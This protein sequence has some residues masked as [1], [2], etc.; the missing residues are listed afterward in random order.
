MIKRYNWVSQP[1]STAHSD[2][3][4]VATINAI[5]TNQLLDLIKSLSSKGWCIVDKHYNGGVLYHCSKITLQRNSAELTIKWNNQHGGHI[6]GPE[7]LIHDIASTRDF[8][9]VDDQRLAFND[10]HAA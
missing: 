7:K 2:V 5:P 9:A 8:T 10:N 6:E 3:P 4:N 1:Q